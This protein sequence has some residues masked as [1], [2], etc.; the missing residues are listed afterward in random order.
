MLQVQGQSR[1]RSRKTNHARH[2]KVKVIGLIIIA[3]NLLSSSHIRDKKSTAGISKTSQ[4]LYMRPLARQARQGVVLLVLRVLGDD[5]CRSSDTRRLRQ[6]AA[7]IVDVPP[8]AHRTLGPT[9]TDHYDGKTKKDAVTEIS[10][11]CKDAAHPEFM[12]FGV[13]SHEGDES[14]EQGFSSDARPSGTGTSR[15]P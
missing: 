1:P 14:D 4:N 5:G 6:P 15:R 13:P 9:T 11:A 8:T 7:A 12:L 2:V 3:N 10:A